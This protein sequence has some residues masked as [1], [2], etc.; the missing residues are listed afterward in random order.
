MSFSNEYVLLFDKG[1]YIELYEDRYY[2]IIENQDWVSEDL[3]FL[4]E[5]L[6]EYRIDSGLRPYVECEK[7]RRAKKLRSEFIEAMK[8][9]SEDLS[10]EMGFEDLKNTKESTFGEEIREVIWDLINK[11]DR[12]LNK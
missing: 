11:Y 4:E 1:L 9:I 5:I 3:C 8:I 7:E 6:A 10:E 2:L 12:N